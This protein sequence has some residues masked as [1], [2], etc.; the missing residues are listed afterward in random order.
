M[1]RALQV[2][3]FKHGHVQLALVFYGRTSSVGLRK[4]LDY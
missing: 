2:F 1:V 4:R 3:V